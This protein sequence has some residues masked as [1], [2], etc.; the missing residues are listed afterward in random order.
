M[1]EYDT[2]TQIIFITKFLKLF[3]IQSLCDFKT[4]ISV[5][6]LKTQKDF[7]THINELVP[8]LLSLFPKSKIGLS[9]K[10]NKIDTEEL[11]VA[12]LLKCL[13]IL[14]IGFVKIHKS[15]HNIVRLVKP[16][17]MYMQYIFNQTMNDIIQDTDIMKDIDHN[18]HK[19]N[20]DDYVKCETCDKVHNYPLQSDIEDYGHPTN[21][22]CINDFSEPIIKTI[23]SQE[24]VVRPVYVK[25]EN[26]KVSQVDFFTTNNG[27]KACILQHKIT[28]KT[29][30]EPSHINRFKY[31]KYKIPFGQTVNLDHVML[32]N[33]K[34]LRN[35]FAIVMEYGG[36]WSPAVNG[37]TLCSLKN[38]GDPNKQKYIEI[39]ITTNDFHLPMNHIKHHEVCIILC[40]VELDDLKVDIFVK[41][42]TNPEYIPIPYDQEIRYSNGMHNTFV[43]HDNMC[44]MLRAPIFMIPYVTDTLIQRDPKWTIVDGKDMTVG[45][46]MQVTNKDGKVSTMTHQEFH[47]KY[48]M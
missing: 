25:D 45:E 8:E 23:E 27:D 2:N 42:E 10:N 37:N 3:N 16:N 6:T 31:I 47:E 15:T 4:E 40:F 32:T 11:A 18:N 33:V 44:G 1:S 28:Y 13:N 34:E 46:L 35:V 7:L 39:P 24:S 36:Y 43:V 17:L 9:R 19:I 14:N 21:S 38:I 20:F 22:P 41:K 29:A 12:T 5:K 26:G 30:Y 48:C